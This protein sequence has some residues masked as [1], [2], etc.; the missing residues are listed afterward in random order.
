MNNEVPKSNFSLTK[1]IAVLI[2]LV[3][4][5]YNWISES[6]KT[7]SAFDELKVMTIES[8]E[9]RGAFDKWGARPNGKSNDKILMS[10]TQNCLAKL[11]EI[12]DYRYGEELKS[13]KVSFVSKSSIHHLLYSELSSGK[14]LLGG[15]YLLE[16]RQTGKKQ[17]VGLGNG[18]ESNCL[19]NIFKEL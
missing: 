18:M 4:L 2:F 7:N 8:V 9:L 14:I 13:K 19:H 6:S 3:F 16:S 10:E 15:W 11:K 1:A 12:P 5:I 17:N